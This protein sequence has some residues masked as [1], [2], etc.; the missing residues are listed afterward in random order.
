VVVSHG[1]SYHTL[2]GN[3]SKIFLENGAIIKEGEA[4]GDVGES[5]ALGTSGLYFEIRY[6]GKPLDPQQW[7]SK[8]GG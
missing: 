5:T 3:L 8:S 1:G 6:K 2:Y 4:I 7:L